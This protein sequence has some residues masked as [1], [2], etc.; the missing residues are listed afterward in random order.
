MLYFIAMQMKYIEKIINAYEKQIFSSEYVITLVVSNIFTRYTFARCKLNKQKK[1]IQL[2]LEEK[3]FSYILPILTICPL[4]NHFS[5]CLWVITVDSN[6]C[7]LFGCI[8]TYP[9]CYDCWSGIEKIV[10]TETIYDH[11]TVYPTCLQWLPVYRDGS[12][13]TGEHSLPVMMERPPSNYP[14]ITANIQLPGTKW[15]DNHKGL[16]TVCVEAISSVHAQVVM[17]KMWHSLPPH[18][19][20]MWP[21]LLSLTFLKCSW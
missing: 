1:T 11:S 12:L 15:V 2:L 8:Q 16:F 9:D 10:I 5:S 14:Y 3:M 19:L 18:T 4:S 20:L 21:S 17:W 6:I 13:Q 7:S